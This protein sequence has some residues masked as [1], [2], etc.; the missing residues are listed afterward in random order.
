MPT[1]LPPKRVLRSLWALCV[2][3]PAICVWGAGCA[4]LVL[5]DRPHVIRQ[6]ASA[7]IANSAMTAAPFLALAYWGSCRALNP[8]PHHFGRSLAAAGA[9]G[10]V[11]TFLIWGAF[12]YEGYTYWAEH[13]TSGVP[14]GSAC[15]MVLSPAIVGVAM[16]VGLWLFGTSRSRRAE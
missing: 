16:L 1:G 13:R 8:Q 7:W 3:V 15:W 5:T 6:V 9:L 14:M 12:Y 2:L 11:F 4:F 10:A